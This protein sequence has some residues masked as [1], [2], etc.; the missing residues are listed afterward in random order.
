LSTLLGK[1][2]LDDA[3]QWGIMYR[4]KYYEATFTLVTVLGI[5]LVEHMDGASAEAM[6]SD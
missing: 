1:D 6:W 3:A 5:P 4:G 2:S